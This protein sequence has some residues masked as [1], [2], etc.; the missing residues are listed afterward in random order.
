[1]VISHIEDVGG[2]KVTC[3]RSKSAR[4]CYEL[5]AHGCGT[6]MKAR[7]CVVPSVGRHQLA[8]VACCCTGRLGGPTTI[9]VLRHNYTHALAICAPHRVIVRT[10]LLAHRGCFAH[11]K[12]ISIAWPFSVITRQRIAKLRIAVRCPCFIHLPR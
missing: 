1:M 2:T 9:C 11:G 7:V 3:R 8:M 6:S 10:R 4:V 5:S 12:R